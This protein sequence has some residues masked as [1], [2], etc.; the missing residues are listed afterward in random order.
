[1]FRGVAFV[2]LD[3]LAKEAL[4]RRYRRGR[5]ERDARGIEKH[6]ILETG[7][8]P[9]KIFPRLVRRMIADFPRCHVAPE[10]NMIHYQV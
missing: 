6:A 7:K 8:R 10:S 9:P 1:M 2:A 5:G 3:D 4:D